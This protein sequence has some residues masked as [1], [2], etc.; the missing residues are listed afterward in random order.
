MAYCGHNVDAPDLYLHKTT[1]KLAT[2]HSN[3]YYT[4]VH[5]PIAG[6]DSSIQMENI[7]DVLR[8]ERNS[9]R[10]WK[11]YLCGPDQFVIM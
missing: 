8:L 9:L 4:P 11:I 1:H 6:Q 2:I 5:S 10:G 3:L 7:N